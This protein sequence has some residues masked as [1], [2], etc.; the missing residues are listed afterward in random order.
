MKSLHIIFKTSAENPLLNAEHMPALITTISHFRK[1]ASLQIHG[2]SVAEESV[3]PWEVIP[4]YTLGSLESLLISFPGYNWSAEI[5]RRNVGISWSTLKSINLTRATT[6][7]SIEILGDCALYLPHLEQLT[8]PI[9]ASMIPEHFV[10]SGRSTKKNRRTARRVP[11]FRAQLAVYRVV[12]RRDVPKS[13]CLFG[14]F[15]GRRRRR[16]TVLGASL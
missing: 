5:L 2:R 13:G 9:D 11:H 12:H 15:R 14:R 8:L 7:S 16:R 3:P 6:L 4:L 1:L 10:P